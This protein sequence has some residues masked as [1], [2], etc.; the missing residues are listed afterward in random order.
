MHHG[1]INGHGM[2]WARNNKWL[3]YSIACF[4]FLLSLYEGF[5]TYMSDARIIMRENDQ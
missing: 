4:I 2:E 5:P 3:P 1:I